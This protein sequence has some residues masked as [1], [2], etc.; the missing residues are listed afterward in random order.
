MK[1]IFFSV[2]ISTSCFAEGLITAHD[3]VFQ[4]NDSNGFRQ[5]KMQSAASDNLTEH[6]SDLEA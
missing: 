1:S 4:K 5:L 2:V 3:F 6:F